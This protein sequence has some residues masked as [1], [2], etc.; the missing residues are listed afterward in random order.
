MGPSCGLI[1][2]SFWAHFCFILVVFW[3]P[4]KCSPLL[5][6]NQ[7]SDCYLQHFRG[8]G[9]NPPAPNVGRTCKCM[10]REARFLL[11]TAKTPVTK[12]YYR[13]S[14]FR[15]GT[16]GYP[17]KKCQQLQQ[18]A[19][20]HNEDAPRTRSKDPLGGS[21]ETP[22]EDQAAPKNTAGHTKASQMIPKRLFGASQQPL[23][24][25]VSFMSVESVDPAKVLQIAFKTG[26]AQ[27]RRTLKRRTGDPKR[28]SGDGHQPKIATRKRPSC[29]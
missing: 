19:G 25:D 24:K 4:E 3:G 29:L 17:N 7:R 12:K 8:V 23:W 6:P 14:G 20:R 26:L 11:D 16:Q 21:H 10:E 13:K 22:G 27:T 2:A 28:H 18:D 15:Q 1:L 9:R 5:L